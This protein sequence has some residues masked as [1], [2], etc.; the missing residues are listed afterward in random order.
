MAVLLGLPQLA[1]QGLLFAAACVLAAGAVVL[2][3][4]RGRF[5]ELMRDRLTWIVGVFVVL[6]GLSG[7]LSRHVPNALAQVAVLALM[8]CVL[9]FGTGIRRREELVV[10]LAFIVGTLAAFSIAAALLGL[11]VPPVGIG[12][13]GRLVGT[14]SNANYLGMVSAFAIVGSATIAWLGARSM[15]AGWAAIALLVVPSLVW[16]GSRGA[17]IAA[18]VG[19]AVVFVLARWWWV[20]VAEGVLAAAAL[21]VALLTPTFAERLAGSDFTSGRWALYGEA[22]ELWAQSPLVGI[23]YRTLELT[24]DTRGFSAH[25]LPL[26]V[27]VETGIL[28]FLAF[29]ALIAM[30]FW[31]GGI[32]PWLGLAITVL[33]IEQTESSMLGWAG[34]TAF[35]FWF[36]LFV[37][38]A[39]RGRRAQTTPAR[40]PRERRKTTDAA[41]E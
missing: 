34:P 3:V 19:L 23:G 18:A 6:A 40:I 41:T 28:G 30:I 12:P 14:F 35:A 7:A 15:R 8:M 1:W 26:A 39:N 4:R 17:M 11:L 22:L 13:Y 36:A 38:G 29:A 20:L 27:L 5:W 31:R 10:D 32:G 24:A 16:S 25:N 2:T 21:A 9:V 33:V 37:H